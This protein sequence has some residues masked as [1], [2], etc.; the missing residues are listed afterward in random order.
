MGLIAVHREE[1]R[2]IRG[3][4]RGRHKTGRIEDRRAGSRIGHIGEPVRVG[5]SG[6]PE[7]ATAGVKKLAIEVENAAS[8]VP[9]PTGLSQ[10]PQVVTDATA[11]ALYTLWL[12]I[13]AVTAL[14]VTT[15][16]GYPD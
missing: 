8:V 13:P 4:C 2:N 9:V 5:R 14:G 10:P 3:P 15:L 6:Q 7:N 1:A 11:N 12:N 16:R